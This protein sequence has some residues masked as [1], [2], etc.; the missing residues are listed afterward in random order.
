[1]LKQTWWETAWGNSALCRATIG[2]LSSL[3]KPFLSSLPPPPPAALSPPARIHTCSPLLA[4]IPLYL[5]PALL[6]LYMSPLY[7]ALRYTLRSFLRSYLART[8]SPLLL[9]PPDSPSFLI[10]F[11][12][13]PSPS[14]SLTHSLSL[15]ITP[16][17]SFSFCLPFS[18]SLPT[19]V[20]RH[21]RRSRYMFFSSPSSFLPAAADSQSL[22]SSFSPSSLP[23]HTPSYPVHVT[24]FLPAVLLSLST[25]GASFP[26][27][28][29]PLP[30]I[31]V[32]FS[33]II[34]ASSTLGYTHA[35]RK[36]NNDGGRLICFESFVSCDK[37]FEN[38]VLSF[39]LP[40][41]IR[42]NNPLLRIT[43]PH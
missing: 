40:A 29:S 20:R 17:L 41:I 27:R 23:R 21:R 42:R 19:S 3:P 35:P 8:W 10:R 15:S 18:L 25:N 34:P 32:Q 13:L 12:S 24:L 9:S 4:S 7:L 31:H 5:A 6:F 14:H 36:R 22:V 39:V 1:M 2:C 30:T 11:L 37:S 43:T 16:T 38:R 28:R 26:L 33:L